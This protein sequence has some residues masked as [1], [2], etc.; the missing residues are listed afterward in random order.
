[1]FLED[2][3]S[4]GQLR[5]AGGNETAG[6][7]EIFL[8][9]EWGTVCD[10]WWGLDDARVAC[11]QLGFP[12]AISAPIYAAFGEGSGP[13]HLDELVCDEG[14]TDLLNCGHSRNPY[15]DHSEDAGVVCVPLS[16]IT[17][18]CSCMFA[19]YILLF[20]FNLILL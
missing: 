14:E 18:L 12:G 16:R 13:I 3:P 4:I 5:L 9:G 7:V 1:M 11:H 15:C 17:G 8:D 20:S 6:R 2:Q 10:D 19:H